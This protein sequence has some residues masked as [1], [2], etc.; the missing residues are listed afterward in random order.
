MALLAR[1]EQQIVP[2]LINNLPKKFQG[3]LLAEKAKILPGNRIVDLQFKDENG[4][5][6]FVECKNYISSRH[7]GDIIDLYSA[8]LN[9]TPEPRN[10]KL[11]IIANKID[12]DAS[13][14]LSRF[15]IL[16]NT[17]RGLGI[18]VSKLMDEQK[19]IR[20]KELTPT[21]ARIVASLD[22]RKSRTVNVDSISA[23]AHWNNNYAKQMLHRLEKKRWLE[24]I[25]KG[26]YVFIP[27][28][29]G[30]EQRFPPLDPLAVANT[31]VQPYYLSY[32][33]LRSVKLDLES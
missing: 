8:I 28:D 23:Q 30:Y 13:K 33:R 31:L 5:D 15:K 19:T 4:N 9:S 11:I 2:Y 12:A 21:E 16:T 27:P 1:T 14:E 6:V 10:P 26:N 29:Y 24:R 20:K 32:R 25:S 18:P 7:L 22:N 17:L 3:Y